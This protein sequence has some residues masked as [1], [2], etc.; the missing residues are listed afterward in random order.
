MLLQVGQ[1]S[2]A[3]IWEDQPWWGIWSA[4]TMGSVVCL[5]SGLHS[6]HAGP[7]K[8]QLLTSCCVLCRSAPLEQKAQQE[9]LSW[10]ACIQGSQGNRQQIFLKRKSPPPQ[11]WGWPIIL[12]SLQMLF[13]QPCWPTERLCWKLFSTGENKISLCYLFPLKQHG[14]TY[15]VKGKCHTAA[16]LTWL[17]HLEKTLIL[18]AG[19]LILNLWIIF[20]KSCSQSACWD[21]QLSC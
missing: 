11:V 3:G 10:G 21:S 8:T 1:G 5:T 14:G 20:S 4:G 7:T 6:C 9:V 13:G 15:P 17:K 18:L 16:A 2:P 12:F 19:G